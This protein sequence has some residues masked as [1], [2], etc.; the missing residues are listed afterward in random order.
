MLTTR[1]IHMTRN[2]LTPTLCG[3]AGTNRLPMERHATPQR[4]FV[5]TAYS[6]VSV[7]YGGHVFRTLQEL[8]RQERKLWQG[9]THEDELKK[10]YALD[11]VNQ[12]E[13]CCSSA[14]NASLAGI[15]GLVW[16]LAIP[17]E[18]TTRLTTRA[19]NSVIFPERRLKK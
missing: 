4:N 1:V 13:W 18:L 19:V 11:V 7:L 16:P 10:N 6:I 9:A 17:I 2:S 14:L 8:D 5:E 3:V 15:S 12:V